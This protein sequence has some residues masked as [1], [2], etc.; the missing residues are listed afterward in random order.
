MKI[1]FEKQFNQDPEPSETQ[2][3]KWPEMPT[4]QDKIRQAQ[5]RLEQLKRELSNFNL[6]EN[7]PYGKEFLPTH[8]SEYQKNQIEQMRKE[9]KGLEE[10]IRYLETLESYRKE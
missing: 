3:G 7:L 4:N 10:E 9:V 8:F 6:P 2:K 5:E 1:N